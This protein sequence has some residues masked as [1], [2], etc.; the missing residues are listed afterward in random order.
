MTE[1]LGSCIF[2]FVKQPYAVGDKCDIKGVQLEVDKISLMST[3]FIRIDN[4]RLVQLSHNILNTLWIENLSRSKRLREHFTVLAS[5][6]TPYDIIKELRDDIAG[7]IE[8]NRRDF[9]KDSV[10][11]QLASISDLT[12][13]EL[14]IEIEHKVDFYELSPQSSKLM[15]PV[16]VLRRRASS[17][18]KHKVQVGPSELPQAQGSFSSW[19]RGGGARGAVASH[20]QPDPLK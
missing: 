5:P 13:L 11:I 7:F 18:S 20:I 1:F 14:E 3:K 9:C 4:K 15:V 10:N 16:Q 8:N 19:S 17:R 2:L 6:D 12:K